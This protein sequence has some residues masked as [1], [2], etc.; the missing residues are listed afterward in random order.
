MPVNWDLNLLKP[1]QDVFGESVRY[2]PVNG[3]AYDITGIFDRAYTQ[4]VEPPEEGGPA[5]NT[6]KPVLGVRDAA[7]RTPPVRGDRVLIKRISTWFVVADIQPD[8]HG[9]TRLELNRIKT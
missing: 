1:L 6:T 3:D 4:D 2:Q 7:F 8:S 9:G 5:I